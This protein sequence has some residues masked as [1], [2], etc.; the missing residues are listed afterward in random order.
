M[1]LKN[2]FIGCMAF[3]GLAIS[4]KAQDFVFSSQ[5]SAQKVGLE[6]QFQLTFSLQNAG[7]VNDF[8]APSFSG[9]QVLGGPFQ[10]SQES[11]SQVNGRME[12]TS[13]V[14]LT[15]LLKP[16]KTGKLT[17]KGAVATVNNHT[18][19][20]NDVHIQV[21]PGSIINQNRQ[22]QARRSNPNPFDDPFFDEI[23]KQ[24]QQMQ[25]QMRQM[26]QQAFGGNGSHQ[27]PG[28]RLPEPDPKTMG[29]ANLKDNIFIK[30]TVDNQHPYVGQQINTSYKL[31][32]RLP[33]NMS[34][35]QLPSLNGFWSEDYDLPSVPKP[36]IERINGKEYQVFLLKKSALFPQHEGTLTL[37]PAK[38]EGTVR[39][40]RKN[41]S[42]KS[43]HPF[44]TFFMDDPFFDDDAFGAYLY[45]DI[46]TKLASTPIAI[47]VQPLP[48]EGQ[49]ESFT[50]A[51]GQFTLGAKIDSSAVRQG[52]SVNL[53]L[54]LKGVGNFK[55]I[56][57]PAIEFPEALNALAPVINDSITQRT[58]AIVGQKTF[59]YNLSPQEPGDWEIPAV[60]LSYFDP[61]TKSYKTLKTE[62]IR[63]KV[64]RGPVQPEIENKEVLADIH[65]LMLLAPTI[66]RS[67]DF[68]SWIW[69]LY[70]ITLGLFVFGIWRQKRKENQLANEDL[71]RYKKANKVAWK[72]LSAA[73]RL[74]N[75]KEVGLAFYEE[76]SKAVW[77]Y[78]SDKLHLPISDLSKENIADR[79]RA[80]EVPQAQI[81]Q[82]HHLIC[83]CEMALYS[84]E[85]EKGQKNKILDEAAQLIGELEQRL[86]RKA[87]PHLVS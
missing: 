66:G 55:L 39:V 58:P 54:T 33:M 12:R 40:L 83:E 13:T 15:Y 82:I 38:A 80:K 19:T 10:S 7:R 6:D 42:T 22:P 29:E 75:K 84:P 47:K 2:F 5:A 53:T 24:Q 23:R 63:L 79:L 50:G 44:S 14:Q 78:L 18:Y 87:Q 27:Q 32:T 52:G 37:D 68:D 76:V 64:T 1:L 73:R 11:I 74:I 48:K 28:S 45:Q 59:V 3:I 81:E 8:N 60:V 49:P 17:I 25:Q 86:K 51:V 70:P 85:G 69:W 43:Q 77:L 71:W 62:P 61:T 31:Y 56:G 4:A 57:N 67:N 20:S 9:F 16:R 21:V 72:R 41:K 34:L 35:T 26:M 36:V 65:P 46:R 30:V